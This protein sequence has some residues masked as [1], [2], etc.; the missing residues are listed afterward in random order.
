VGLSTKV[1]VDV[2]NVSGQ[3]L[4]QSAR[5]APV[6]ATNAYDIDRREVMARIAHIIQENTP[7]GSGRFAAQQR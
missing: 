2:R 7:E 4:A 3:I 1:Q 6:L 5:Q